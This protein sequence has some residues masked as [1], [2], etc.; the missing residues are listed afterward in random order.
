MGSDAHITQPVR[1]SLIPS[2]K[3][4]SIADPSGNVIELIEGYHDEP[5][6]PPP[7][8]NLEAQ[9]PVWRRPLDISQAITAARIGNVQQLS[10]WLN[11]GGNPD[12]YDSQGWTPLLA[13]AVR[14]QAA[15]VDLLL[16]APLRKADPEMPHRRSGALPIHYA[17]QSGSVRTS[18][19]LLDA[20]PDH[21]D[22]IWELNGH[23]L[24]LQA[25]FYGYLQLAEFALH[26]GAD[27]AATTVRGL[28]GMELAQQFQNQPMIDLIRPYDSPQDAKEA[29][30]KVLLGRIAPVTPSAQAATQRLSNSLVRI[31][32]DGLKRAAQHADSVETTL[33]EVRNLVETQRID[34]N[35]LGGPLQQPPLVVV[36]TGNNGSPANKNVA[37]LRKRLAEYLLEGG[38][39]PT[40]RELHPMAVHAIIRAAVFNHLEILQMIGR[41]L[42]PH[43]LADALNEQPIVNGLTALHDTVLRVTTAGPD[44]FEGY[45]DQIRWFVANGA[46]GDIE[47]FS[48]RTQRSIAE[49]ARDPET[50]RRILDALGI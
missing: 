16:H 24:F 11:A 5:N 49:G 10:E 33:R 6:P 50:R 35:R 19:F 48:G 29:Y 23:T 8:A 18:E 41:R 9:T 3:I 36:V 22:R 46:R 7:P 40:V 31:I 42:T 39:D 30:Y 47:D 38:A 45:L 12:Q 14:R 1:P 28:G 27:T 34:V 20:Q 44:R 17:G 26:R 32:E 4:A 13:A 43:A 21:L 25:V 2:S 37:K 15:A